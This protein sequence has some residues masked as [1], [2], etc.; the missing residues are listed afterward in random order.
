[1]LC[2]SMYLSL[3]VSELCSA[4]LTHSAV[5]GLPSRKGLCLAVDGLFAGARRSG[6][7]VLFLLRTLA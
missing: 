4:K 6:V 7:N 5:I 3:I 2:R 1:V